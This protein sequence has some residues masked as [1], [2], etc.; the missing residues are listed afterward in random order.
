MRSPSSRNDGFSRIAYLASDFR[1]ASLRFLVDA[2]QPD[3]STE[4]RYDLT[5]AALRPSSPMRS[6]LVPV[7]PS[8]WSRYAPIVDA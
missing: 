7:L 6:R 1:A 8:T 4:S 3:A 2:R 5:C